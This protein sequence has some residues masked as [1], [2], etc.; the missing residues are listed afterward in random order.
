M[1]F[2]LRENGFSTNDLQVETI[3]GNSDLVLKKFAE[4]AG[5]DGVVLS[6]PF[7]EICLKTVK[8][9]RILVDT[10]E[11]LYENTIADVLIGNRSF[12]ETHHDELSE[13]FKSWL[14]IAEKMNQTPQKCCRK[15]QKV[16]FDFFFQ[17]VHAVKNMPTKA[18]EIR[19]V[20][21]DVIL[22]VSALN[23]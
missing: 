7:I 23:W 21:S 20:G 6:S 11:K 14:N 16:E 15:V 4:D 10:S 9:T 8:N 12:V 3:T 13:L 1:L 22:L 5:F 2:I 17:T 18:K 19:S